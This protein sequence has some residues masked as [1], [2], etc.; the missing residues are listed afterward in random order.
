MRKLS[1]F[2]GVFV[3]V[4]LSGCSSLPNTISTTQ[5]AAVTGAQGAVH[6]GQSPIT[7][8]TITLWAVGTTG[9][10]STAT[11]L[12]TTTTNANGAF[13]LPTY[14][15]PGSDPYVYLTSTG[16]NPGLAPGTN[17]T[18]IALM[19][20]LTDCNTLKANAATEFILVDEVTTIGSVAA[21]YPYIA[22]PGSVGSGTGDAAAFGTAFQSVAEYTNTTTGTAPGPN[23][24]GGYYAS[25]TE[26]NT[27]GNIFAYCINTA[28]GS[29]GD[30]TPCGNLFNLTKVGGVAPTNTLN[31]LVNILNN[32]T[33]N[34]SGLFGYAGSNTP[35]QPADS[36]APSSW[37]LPIQAIVATP[38]FSIGT[39][40]YGAAQSVTLSDTTSGAV[41]HY[42]T[43]G[44]TPTSGSPIPSGAITVS[45]SETINAIA[46]AGGYATSAVASATYTISGSPGAYSVSGQIVSPTCGLS[47]IPVMTVTLKQGGTT[48][49]TVSTNV[50]SFTFTGVANG[51]YTITPSISG[52]SSVFYPSSQSV[53]VNGSNASTTV[54]SASLGYSVS[55]TV[56]YSGSHTGQIYLALNPTTCSGGGTEGTSVSRAGSFTIH[57]V[58][59]GSYTLQA[60]MDTLG[61]GAANGAEP[62][63]SMSVTVSGANYSGANVTLADAGTVTLSSA[64]TLQGVGGFN[65]GIIA[66]FKGITSS[67]VEQPTSYTL[68]WSTT[69]SF[70]TVTGSQT[71]PAIGTHSNV[72][73]TNSANQP[74]LTTGSTYYFRAFGTSGGTATGPYSNVFGPVTIGPPAP[75]GGVTVSGTV[76]FTGAATGPLYTGFFNQSTGAFY[77]QYIA[78]PANTQAYSVQVPTGSNYLFV[79]ILDQNNNGVV[80]AGDLNDINGS[81]SSLPTVITGA[82]SNENLTLPSGPAVGTVTT[83]NGQSTTSSGTS[84]FFGMNVQVKGLAKQPV[85]VELVS[86]P[87]VINPI[88]MALCGTVG[89]SCGQGYQFTF[90]LGSTSPNV[91]DTYTFNVTYSDGTTGTVTAVVTGVLTNFATNLMPTTGTSS[92]TTPTFS[93]IDPANASSYI[94][95]FQLNDSSG[96]T[97]W[98]IPGNNANASGFSSSITSVP[99]ST[100][101]DP[102]GA[103]NPPT[104]TSLST[105]TVY[106]WQVSAYD[107][108]GNAAAVS[109]QYQP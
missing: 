61:Y 78:S 52:P 73:F 23:L 70:T 34:V 43:D 105:S 75:V 63:G 24:P 27:L 12:A 91:G 44:S 49:Q 101:V 31:A 46:V 84:Q 80:D 62:T 18:D 104:L 19:A 74:T 42:T 85:A 100:T 38:T 108:Y 28:S 65:N 36:V 29:A 106:T 56:A 2:L 3:A 103:T 10:G 97:I 8:A 20:A 82:T 71:F 7:G 57:G 92:S 47:N 41:I 6:G 102:T 5:V 99:W 81:G 39:G 59:P 14:T 37:A 67:S 93:W 68:Q 64:P 4:L 50:G 109:V 72:W 25:S 9:D 11:S 21:L 22:G 1:G 15:C 54:F 88:D 86:G 55:G 35:F 95:E 33:Q 30:G 13:T 79:G 17:N 69:N 107:S 48:V 40:T 96:N 89:T 32:P 90:Y 16:G 51:T 94:Y 53:T 77:G 45:S 58:P 60:S 26:I 98:Q 87:N 83:E 66:Q 76:S